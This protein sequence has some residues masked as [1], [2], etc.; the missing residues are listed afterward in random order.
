MVFNT[1]IFPDDCHKDVDT[2]ENI[3]RFKLVNKE[4]FFT[5]R[6]VRHRNWLPREVVESP[7]L[8]SVENTGG[9]GIWKSNCL[10]VLG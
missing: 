3:H 10:V 8:G 9:C 4:N 6:V 2:S 5:E 1:S 7:I